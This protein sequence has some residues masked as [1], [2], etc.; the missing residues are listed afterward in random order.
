[1]AENDY[2]AGSFAWT[3]FDYKG[4]PTPFAWPCI[5]SHFG[6]MDM[7]GFP[8]DGYY[9]YQSWWTD[10]PVLHIFPHWNWAGK[11]G[12]EVEVWCYSNC[13]Q[14]GTVPQRQIAG[15]P[16]D[17]TQCHLVWKVKYEPG[18]LLA[19]GVR[20]GKEITTKVETTDAPAVVL[21]P[22]RTKLT[23]DGE[24]MSPW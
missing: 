10:Q 20:D 19:K 9:Y 3:G 7:C 15:R 1:M 21:T 2:M 16:G 24:P 5:N 22:D 6:I 23:A 4:E 18:T 14:A 13:Q 11:E 17:E 8:K 12:Q